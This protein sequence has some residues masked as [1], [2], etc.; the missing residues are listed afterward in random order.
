MKKAEM[1]IGTLI[2]FIAMIL[3]AA[4]AAG[5]LIQTATSLQNKAL[6]AGDRTRG[7][8]STA[9]TPLLVFGEDG[10]TGNITKIFMK[11]KLAPGADPIKFN[12][13]LIEV[14]LQ[15][16]SADLNFNRSDGTCAD[17]EYA[18]DSNGEGN[19]SVKYLIQGSEW[20][21]GYLHRGDVAMVCLA[22]PRGITPDE[23]LSLRLV[24]KVGTSMTVE[25]AVP[26]IINQRRV[27]IFP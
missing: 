14:D 20:N 25:T 12:D 2:I 13:S 15:D 3:V 27:Y 24:P 5:V 9:I 22:S 17:G 26:D 16:A 21:D 10:T 4:I 19:F 18:T 8:V 6:L 23:D 11:I 7:Q 1:G